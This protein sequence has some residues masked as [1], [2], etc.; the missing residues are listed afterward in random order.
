M[1]LFQLTTLGMNHKQETK[2]FTAFDHLDIEEVFRDLWANNADKMSLLYRGTPAMKTDITR[3]GTR[4]CAGR[5][6][7]IYIGASMYYISN[8]CDGY[9]QDCLDIA[10]VKLAATKSVSSRP[11]SS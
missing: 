5:I 9:N 7:D 4:T 6:R 3:T 11:F 1:V 8:F 10:L 2:A